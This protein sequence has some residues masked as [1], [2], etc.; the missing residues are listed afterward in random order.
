[1]NNYEYHN[2]VK[3]V[4]GEGS[5][6]KL[7]VLLPA[8][9]PLVLLY[10]GGSIKHNGVYDAVKQ[11]VPADIA[12]EFGGITPNP[13]HTTCMQALDAMAGLSDPFLLAVGGGSVLDAAKYIAAAWY[14]RQQHGPHADP[15]DILVKKAAVEQALPIG[16]VLTLP[17]TGS[18]MNG[19][20]V[21]S[22]SEHGEKRG[23][24]SAKVM[25]V[26]SILD[27]TTSY[28]LPLRQTANGIVDTFVHV[29]EQYLTRDN[30]SPL[31]DR[32]AEG[33][34]LTLIE[35]GKRALMQAHDYPTRAA[36]MQAS[37]LALNGLLACGTIQDWSTHMIGHE[38]TA[39]HGLDHAQSLA[40]VLP[41]VLQHKQQAKRAKLIQFAQRVWGL[42]IGDEQVLMDEAIARTI[43]FFESLGVETRLSDYQ[44]DA[45]CAEIIGQRIASRGWM[46]GED[47]DIDG[48]AV[49]SILLSRI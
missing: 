45:S 29:T 43:L 8:S 46:L 12:C 15:W 10:G 38:L 9:R 26:F 19:N 37:C 5:C 33:I 22:R 21:I 30:D 42:S 40:V 32:L 3:I 13:E 44:L 39:L 1:M 17:A 18:E 48:K 25:P 16:C 36:L 35:R 41:G 14:F 20:S 27:P 28:S 49:Q 11:H 47:A 2:P 23:F 7:P 31:T 6:Q 34:L 4:F 24:N